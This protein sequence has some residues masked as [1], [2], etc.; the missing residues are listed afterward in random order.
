MDNAT[1]FSEINDLFMISI[2]N[3]P[4]LQKMFDD[5]IKNN[6]ITFEY[7]CE[8]LLIKSI[9][10]FDNCANDLENRDESLRQFNCKLS[11]KEKNILAEW[12]MYF[13]FLRMVNDI[14]SMK[15]HLNDSDFKHYA[16]SQNLTAKMNYKNN[17]NEEINLDMMNYGTKNF[18]QKYSS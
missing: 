11:T 13:W 7:F 4:K 8:G 2:G 16:E 17:I 9:A 10:K 1:P 6:D 3:D 5:F 12:M 14:N 15:L 18:L